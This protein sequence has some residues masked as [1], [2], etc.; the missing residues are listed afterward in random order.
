MANI[1]KIGII[2]SMY[3]TEKMVEVRDQLKKL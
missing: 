3:H 2:G 1:M